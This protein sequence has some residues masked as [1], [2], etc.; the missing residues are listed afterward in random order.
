MKQIQQLNSPK[1]SMTRGECESVHWPMSSQPSVFW[2]VQ[3]VLI[4]NLFKINHPPQTINSGI[5]QKDKISKN[6]IRVKREQK[7]KF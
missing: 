5:S 2:H 6:K 1:R 7:L 4:I 3:K